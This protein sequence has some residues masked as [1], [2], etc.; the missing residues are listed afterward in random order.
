MRGPKITLPEKYP[1]LYGHYHKKADTPK[2]HP[3]Q[4][5]ARKE[6][7]EGYNGFICLNAYRDQAEEETKKNDFS[8]H[9]T[10]FGRDVPLAPFLPFF[11]IIP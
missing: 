2:N 11:K 10:L 6:D 7:H 4:S 9:A 3:K 1:Y 5:G 8:V